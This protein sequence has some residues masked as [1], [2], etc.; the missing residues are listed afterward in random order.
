MK[1]KIIKSR[2]VAWC[3]LMTCIHIVC[4]LPLWAIVPLHDGP[5]QMYLTGTH[6]APLGKCVMG[7]CIVSPFYSFPDIQEHRKQCKIRT[8][9]YLLY[10]VPFLSTIVTTR[11]VLGT[12]T[13]LCFHSKVHRKF[14]NVRS[15]SGDFDEP[16]DGQPSH[17]F[18]SLFT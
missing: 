1:N 16:S 18:P 12:C 13:L 7:N 15:G 5:Q 17:N 14:E 2:H 10:L 6:A 8:P 4:V 9:A 11:R 3:K